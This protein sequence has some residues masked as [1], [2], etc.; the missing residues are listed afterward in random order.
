MLL[1]GPKFGSYVI[2]EIEQVS[3]LACLTFPMIYSDGVFSEI[4]QP[5]RRRP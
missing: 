1:P 5:S 4:D 2:T 3:V